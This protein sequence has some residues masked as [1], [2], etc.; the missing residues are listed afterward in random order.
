MLRCLIGAILVVLLPVAAQSS[1]AVWPEKWREHT[2]VK[3]EPLSPPDSSLFSEFGGDRAE[4][5]LYSGPAGK[6]TATAYRL[7]DATGAL[8]WYQATRPDNAIPL[9]GTI[10]G[11][12]TP[13]SMMVMY[14][15]YLLVFEGWRPTSN[16]FRE[17]WTKLPGLRSGGGLPIL[18]GYLPD[19]D[20]IRNSERYVLGPGSLS[21]FQP[22]FPPI[23]AGFEQGAEAQM[24]RFKL[25]DGEQSL[26]I[27]SYPTPQ[28]ARER[29]KEFEKQNNWVAKRSGSYV[30][31]VPDVVNRAA[32][33]ALLAGINYSQNFVWNQATQPPPMPN[34]GGMLIAI[35][36]LTGLLLLVCIG[37]GILMASFW[38][39]LR[40]RSARLTGHEGTM[41][42]LHL[43]DR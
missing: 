28:I 42:T 36:E 31:V 10:I 16:E 7:S 29:V 6:F 35:F 1:R 33:E 3:S 39:Y 11:A 26:I 5:A 24:G 17:L 18:A 40:R 30:A 21:R 32:A 19:K 43:E 14:E 12:T 34:V 8:A 22:R 4:K 41:I 2:R 25:P 37:G 15:N 13:G 20:R 23:L 27:F 38:V 9:R